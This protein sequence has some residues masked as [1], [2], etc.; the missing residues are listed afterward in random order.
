MVH[1][2]CYSD[3]EVAWVDEYIFGYICVN[4]V[5]AGVMIEIYINGVG[6]LIN[7]MKR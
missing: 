4:G 3:I 2:I 6:C 1:W 5:T 7:S